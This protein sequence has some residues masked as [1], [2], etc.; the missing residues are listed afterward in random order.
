MDGGTIVGELNGIPK[1]KIAHFKRVVLIPPDWGASVEPALSYLAHHA[2]ASKTQLKTEEAIEE[3]FRLLD[4]SNPFLETLAFSNLAAA[5]GDK[6]LLFKR[7]TSS[8]GF[9]CSVET[10]AILSQWSDSPDQLLK[11]FEPIILA[12]KEL[13]RLHFM[14]LGI[15]TFAMR[16]PRAKYAGKLMACIRERKAMLEPK[17]DRADEEME[18]MFYELHLF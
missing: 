5:A 4:S 14:A 18:M 15:Y 9:T 11:E 17:D 2:T 16:E 7:L 6:S 1:G 10:F 13:D 12:T 8:S 3:Q